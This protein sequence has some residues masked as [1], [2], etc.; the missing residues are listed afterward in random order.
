MPL[1]VSF[2]GRPV[3]RRRRVDGGLR[4][5]F[6]SPIRGG[7]SHVAVVSQADWLRQ[8]SV[9]FF[10]ESEMPDVRALAAQFEPQLF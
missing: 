6:V 10:L 2:R 1:L 4:L 8:G 5:V 7:K 3:K 9:Q